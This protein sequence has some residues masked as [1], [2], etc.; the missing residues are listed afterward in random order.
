ML[1]LISPYRAA[2]AAPHLPVASC[3]GVVSKDTKKPHTNLLTA[4]RTSHSQSSPMPF[5]PVG[6]LRGSP[7]LLNHLTAL[8]IGHLPAQ[9]LLTSS[10]AIQDI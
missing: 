6:V 8:V 3:K 5:L 7:L 9:L 4:L 2:A 10:L 1:L